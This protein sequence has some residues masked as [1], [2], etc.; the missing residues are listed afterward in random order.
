MLVRIDATKN[1]RNLKTDERI[2]ER[3]NKEKVSI[4]IEQECLWHY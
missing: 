1:E 4:S 2:Y 3:K